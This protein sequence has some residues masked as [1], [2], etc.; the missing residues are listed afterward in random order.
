MAR[1]ELVG[2]GLVEVLERQARR[3]AVGGVRLGH[4]GG[5]PARREVRVRLAEAEG[6]PLGVVVGGPAGGVLGQG[7]D[8]G[9]PERLIG[10]AERLRHRL[11]HGDDERA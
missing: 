1:G 6:A 5:E 3:L 4:E 11:G 7:E 10:P 2:R 8:V 9:E